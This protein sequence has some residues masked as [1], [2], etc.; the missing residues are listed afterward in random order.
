MAGV[1]REKGIKRL[2]MEVFFRISAAIFNFNLHE[3][4]PFSF[5]YKT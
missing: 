2:K 3:K 5:I 1:N 4:K